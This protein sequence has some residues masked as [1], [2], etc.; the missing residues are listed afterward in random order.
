MQ[1]LK[2]PLSRCRE[3]SHVESLGRKSRLAGRPGRTAALEWFLDYAAGRER[4]WITRRID[5]AQHWIDTIRS[6]PE[7]TGTAP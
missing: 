1:A 3:R 7:R 5:I 2:P 4:V 6:V